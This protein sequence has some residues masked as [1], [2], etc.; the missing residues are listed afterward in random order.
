MRVACGLLL[1]LAWVAGCDR[2]AGPTAGSSQARKVASLV[3]AA[4]DML[5]GMG[6]GDRLVAVS[7]YD[8]AAAVKDLPRVGDYQTTD[9]ETLARV[10]PDVMV[11]QLAPERV[12]EGLKERAK[13]LGIELVNVKID[14][15]EDVFD[16]MQQLG[17]VAGEVDKGREATRKL[18]EA[19]DD[20]KE[21]AAKR[22]AVKALVFRNSTMQDVVG[23]DNFLDDL[24]KVLNV[25][26]VAGALGSAWPSID[27]EK[28]VELSPDVVVMLL[29]GAGEAEVAQARRFWVGMERVPAVKNGRV[30][31][32]T[33]DY[34]L[35]PGARL[36]ELAGRLEKCLE[37]K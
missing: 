31:V 29:P 21:R 22:P 15:L 28:V 30:C 36:G 34:A 2:A 20:V 12:P 10:R 13:G 16:S 23:R 26:N 35:V 27:R 1:V 8:T 14:R 11:I 18:R 25:T 7:N 33:E 3:P 5:R 24:L 37:G 32:V 9:W 6:A 17:A 19:L 4:T